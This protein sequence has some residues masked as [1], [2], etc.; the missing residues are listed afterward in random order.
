MLSHLRSRFGIPRVISVIA[1]VFAMLGDAYAATNSS[2]GG[3]ATA[4]AKGKQGPR[5][6][7]DKTGPAGPF[8]LGAVVVRNALYVDPATAQIHAVS[9]PLPQT[10]EGIPLDVCSIALRG[11]PPVHPQPDLLRSDGDRGGR[12]LIAGPKRLPHQPF[13]VGG[14]SQLPFKPRLSLKLKGGTKRA[15]PHGR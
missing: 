11:T 10:I 12:R 15:R 9:D 4:S 13:Q 2:S 3:K 1:L 14:C 7:T 5:G 6:K 8:D